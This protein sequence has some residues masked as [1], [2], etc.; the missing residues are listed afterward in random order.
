MVQFQAY[1]HPARLRS[2]PHR[3]KRGSE[4][5][6]RFT[7]V[8]AHNILTAH[9]S[10]Y[11]LIYIIYR[12]GPNPV[13]KSAQAFQHPLL[14]SRGFRLAQQPRSIPGPSL[15]TVICR[16]VSGTTHRSWNP[17]PVKAEPTLPSAEQ[18]GILDEVSPTTPFTPIYFQVRFAL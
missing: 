17:F 13:T 8:G 15:R 1:A 3:D 7:N 10:I 11:K 18:R 2:M 12:R 9:H 14:T 5:I 6:G 16:S 4:E